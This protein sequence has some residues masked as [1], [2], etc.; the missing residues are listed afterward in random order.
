VRRRRLR[1]V[2]DEPHRIPF[3]CRNRPG[4]GTSRQPERRLIPASER[5]GG[6]TGERSPTRSKVKRPSPVKHFFDS[7][8]P[9][10]RAVAYSRRLACPARSLSYRAGGGLSGLLVAYRRGSPLEEGVTLRSRCKDIVDV[11]NG[12]PGRILESAPQSCRRL[13]NG[14]RARP[15]TTSWGSRTGSAPLSRTGR[16]G[17][18]SSRV[19]SCRCRCR[20]RLTSS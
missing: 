18:G 12:A 16:S 17:P 15:R 1:Q 19:R 14:G 9:S 4:R 2:V 7:R 6:T 10:F 3:D 20:W 13:S 5:S 8:S 11:L